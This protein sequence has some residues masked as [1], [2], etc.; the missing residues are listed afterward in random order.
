MKMLRCEWSRFNRSHIVRSTHETKC[1][2]NQ[3]SALHEH[4]RDKLA[5]QMPA[6]IENDL[7]TLKVAASYYRITCEI[8]MGEMTVITESI[9]CYCV[10]QASNNRTDNEFNMTIRLRVINPI[11]S[12]REHGASL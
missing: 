7:I 8:D 2:F 1:L 12:P 6:Q 4:E 9:V 3:I 10:R 11:T 5:Y